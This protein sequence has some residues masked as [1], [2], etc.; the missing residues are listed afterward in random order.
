MKNIINP[1][2]IFLSLFTILLGDL[3]SPTPF[4]VRQPTGMELNIF[5]RGNHLSNWYEYHGW[6]IVKNTADWWVYA[7][8]VDGQKLLA[9][10]QMVGIAP[11]PDHNLQLAGITGKL[12]PEALVL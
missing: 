6:S 2:F 4:T 8:G 9:S 1:T 11:E 5:I 10:D 12:I 3:A 7:S